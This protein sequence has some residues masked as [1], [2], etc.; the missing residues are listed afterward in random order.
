[1]VLHPPPRV[2]LVDFVVWFVVG[3]N[4]CRALSAMTVHILSA[5]T[6]AYV[7]GAIVAHMHTRIHIHVVS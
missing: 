3:S 1:M 7:R 2:S 6:T 5:S 4:Q